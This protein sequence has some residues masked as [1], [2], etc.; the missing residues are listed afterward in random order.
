MRQTVYRV[1][2]ADTKEHI[3][4]TPI[5]EQAS[6]GARALA[7]NTERVVFVEMDSETLGK[8]AVGYKHDGDIIQYWRIESIA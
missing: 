1:S 2:Y 6:E 3:F 5:R 8:R 7:K 4:T